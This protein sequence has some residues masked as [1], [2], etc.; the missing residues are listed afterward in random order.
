MN[1][2]KAL[3]VIKE[4]QA[5]ALER[6]V[7]AA[8]MERVHRCASRNLEEEEGASPWIAVAAW[9]QRGYVSRET[10]RSLTAKLSS[11]VYTPVYREPLFCL[12]VGLLVGAFLSQAF[13]GL[14]LWIK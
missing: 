8:D 13:L 11:T 9:I 6:A 3:N 7:L 4:D 5:R 1:F 10:P 14:V 12:S 2:Q